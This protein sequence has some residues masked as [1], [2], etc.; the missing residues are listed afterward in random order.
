L[1]RRRFNW[2]G[3]Q[4]GVEQARERRE[5]V[6]SSVPTVLS[7]NAATTGRSQACRHGLLSIAALRTLAG[8]TQAEF[9]GTIEISVHALRSVQDRRSGR[10]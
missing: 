6:H 3:W 5:P 4:A 7:S 9:A 1:A 8:P 2:R 10:S